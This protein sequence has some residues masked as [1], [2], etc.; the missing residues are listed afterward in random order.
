MDNST[1]VAYINKQGGTHSAEMCGFLW[2]IM[3]WCQVEPSPINRIFTASAGVQTD[4][5]KVVHS[6]CRPI[7][8]SSEPQ[9]SIVRISSPR[10]TCLG[11]R[12]PECKLFVSHCLCLPLHGSPSQGDRKNLAKQLPHHSNS[13]RLAGDDLVWGASA[14]HNRDPTPVTRVKNN[15]KTVPHPCVS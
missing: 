2:K 4:L 8:H 9:S 6:S 12:C 5:S 13:P 7:C 11:H 3:T 15:S 10:P 14:V 1:V